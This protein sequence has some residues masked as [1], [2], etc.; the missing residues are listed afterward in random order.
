[1]RRT[2]EEYI[3]ETISIL[4]KYEEIYDVEIEEMGFDIPVI[5]DKKV[6]AL[7]PDYIELNVLDSVKWDEITRLQA[8]ILFNICDAYR[9]IVK[10]L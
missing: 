1:M 6:T 8:F 10:L 2:K 3:K 4:K 5:N 9:R 7:T